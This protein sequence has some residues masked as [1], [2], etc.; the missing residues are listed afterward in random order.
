MTTVPANNGKILGLFPLPTSGVAFSSIDPATGDLTKLGSLNVGSIIAGGFISDVDE[1]KF[2]VIAGDKSLYTFNLSTGAIMNL[3]TISILPQAIVLG[4]NGNLI[5]IGNGGFYSIDP[6]TGNTTLMYNVPFTDGWKFGCFS[7][8]IAVDKYFILSGSNTLHTFNMTDASLI[9]SAALDIPAQLL[10]VVPDHAI[11][12]TV[13]NAESDPPN[14]SLREAQV[15]ING[16]TYLTDSSGNY[17]SN[18]LTNGEHTITVDK[19][20]F[21]GQTISVTFDGTSVIQD[22]SMVPKPITVANISSK[23]NGTRYYLPGI[24]LTVAYDAEIDWNGHDPKTVKFITST[25]TYDVATSDNTASQSI[26]VG[27]EFVPCDTLEVLAIS[28]DGTKSQ[29]KSADF[30]VTQPSS[31]DPSTINIVYSRDSFSYKSDFTLNK[32]LI[33]Q[34]IADGIIM[35]MPVFGKKGFGLQFIPDL[36]FDFDSTAGKATYKM[37]WADLEVGKVLDHYFT[38]R[39]NERGLKNLSNT[40]EHFF[41]TGQLDRRH[42]PKTFIAGAEVS[43]Y[44]E[45]KVESQFNPPKCQYGSSAWSDTGFVGLA[46]SA[47]LN[48]FYQFPFSLSPPYVPWFVK[49]KLGVDADLLLNINSLLNASLTGTATLNPYLAGTLGIG[50]NDVTDAEATL[51]GGIE[52]AW[53]WPPAGL[54]SATVYVQ[55]TGKAVVLLWSWSTGTLRWEQCLAG[56]PRA[57]ELTIKPLSFK[58]AADLTPTLI[59]RDYLKDPIAGAFTISPKYTVKTFSLDSKSYSIAVSPIATSIFPLS[60]AFLSSAGNNVN[61]LYVTDNPARSTN[62]RTMLVHSAFDGSAWSAPQP[63]ADDGT[64]DF[65]PVSLTFS[66]GTII[67]AWEDE[68]TT[69]SDSAGL[70]AALTGLEIST[71]IYNPINKIWS[72]ATRQTTETHLHRTPKLAGTAKNKVILTWLSNDANDLYGGFTNPNKL[73]Y[74]FYNGTSWSTPQ[75][76]AVIPYAVKRY[77]VA[78]DG[79]TV[80]VVLALHSDDGL[81]TLD[82]L[83]LYKITYS[84]DAWGPITRLTNDTIIDDNSQLGLDT[85]GNFILTWMRGNELSSVVNFAFDSRTVIQADTNYSSNLSDFKQ[86]TATDGKVALIYAQPSDTSSSDLYGVFFDPIFKSWGKPK[87]L[88]SDP[89][90]EQHPSIAFLGS[91]T[92]IAAYNRQLMLNANGTAPPTPSNIDLYMLKYAMG[93]DL[94]LDGNLFTVNPPNPA[95]GDSVTF[96]VTARNVGDKPVTDAKIAFYKGNPATGGSKIGE[97]I[98]TGVFNAGESRDASFTWTVPATTQPFSIYAVIDPDAVHDPLSRSDNTVSLTIVQQD[99]ALSLI[100]WEKPA[101]TLIVITARVTNV[102][103]LLSPA[104]TVVFRRDGPTGTLLSTQNVPSLAKGTSMDININFDITA[105]TSPFYTIYVAVDESNSIAEFDKSN[106]NGSVLIPGKSADLM[107]KVT[108]NFSGTG[109]GSVTS[110]PNGLS[111]NAA[112]AN[113]FVWSTALT[114]S[115][116]PAEYSCFSGWNAGTLCSGTSDCSFNVAAPTSVTAIFDMDINHKVRI[117]RSPPVY[118][119]TLQ[120]AVNA[121]ATGDIISVWAL[122]FP[123][124]LF[125]N[126]TV[127]ING[128]FNAAY[129]AISGYSDI[130]GSLS[131][132]KGATTIQNLIIK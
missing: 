78:Y 42:F 81:M 21:E 56:C 120:S 104:T 48:A 69:L 49:G 91:E 130:K 89:E 51:T 73:W 110:T 90:T 9:S 83:E 92:I 109:R 55:G 118:F 37:Q 40:L 72:T 32:A 116:K 96:T 98:L 125:L 28:D 36:S 29:K 88:T 16:K 113:D 26:N 34:G 39:K 62:N 25:N 126:K 67:A 18:S 61:L 12:G 127:A 103:S 47:E 66:D 87:Q 122:D 1:N 75:L 112:C 65:H 19:S 93:V 50:V 71:S 63:L 80:H 8:D 52:S 22:F 13:T 27:K 45:L 114:L 70:N 115:P 79:E 11:S 43:L 44:P 30:I 108:V 100:S 76:A 14:T 64:A 7:S 59:S 68:K 2:Y 123:E 111:C 107:K 10:V 57:V 15:I 106:N 23:Y 128:G 20:G 97:S 82:N 46:G 132:E 35:D 53:G 105:L 74:S 129:S 54:T 4:R 86:A 95:P 33:N 84:A 41:Q 131:I 38:W 99:L 124:N 117:E 6:S 101:E 85:S 5:A 102:G 94:A 119:A 24:D 60:D 77:T 58:D 31:V 17:R 121:A 3:Q